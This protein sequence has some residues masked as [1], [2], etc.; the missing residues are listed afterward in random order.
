MA[1]AV[2]DGRPLA[3]TGALG[4]LLVWD[5]ATRRQ[6]GEELAFPGWADA[7]AIAPDSRL[8]VG[9]GQ[10]VAVLSSR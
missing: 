5:V 7:V 6:I 8:V 3:V 10:E 1:A 4:R 2:I 9:F